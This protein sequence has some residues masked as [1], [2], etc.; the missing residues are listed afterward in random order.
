MIAWLWWSRSGAEQGLPWKVRFAADDIRSAKL[1]SFAG[2]ART[3]TNP[4][5]FDLPDGPKAIIELEGEITV[6]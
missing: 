6:L 1:V 3:L 4:D 5:G 2:N